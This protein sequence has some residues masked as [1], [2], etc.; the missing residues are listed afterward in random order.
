[1]QNAQLL[2]CD[3]D[4]DICDMLDVLFADK[5][6]RVYVAHDAGEVMEGI[7]R[8]NPNCLIIDLHLPDH[9]GFW[10]AAQLRDSNI[11]IPIIFITADEGWQCMESAKNI[12]GPVDVLVKPLDPYVLLQHIQSALG[13]VAHG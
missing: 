11:N 1:M 3:D 8:S 6:F 4:N 7:E 9:D 5:G 2:V 10:I 13:P 12:R